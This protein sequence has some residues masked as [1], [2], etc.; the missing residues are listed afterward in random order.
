M[1]DPN[2][3]FFDI[4]RA[5][6][7]YPGTGSLE[8]VGVGLGDGTTVN[9]LLPADAA[10][11]SI[12]KSLARQQCGRRLVFVLKGG[13]NLISLSHGVK[14]VLKVLAGEDIPEAGPAWSC[15]GGGRAG[16]SSRCIRH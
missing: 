5:A 8:E 7:F 3:L 9:I 11:T 14:S 4:H 1:A 15:R 12:L 13:Y 2:V 10:M 6:P 16:L